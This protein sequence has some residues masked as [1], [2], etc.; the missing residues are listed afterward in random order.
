MK[1]KKLITLV[2]GSGV[3]VA[4]IN[5]NAFVGM[6]VIGLGEFDPEIGRIQSQF[7]ADLKFETEEMTGTS[8][9][10]YKPGKIRDELNMGG[11]QSVMIR[12]LDTNKAYMLMPAMPNMYMEIDPGQNQG[13]NQAPEYKLVSREVVGK[14]EVNG[15]QTTKYKSVY[16]SK[17]GKF[18][19]FTWYTEDNIAVKGFMI[20][21]QKGD[22]QRLKFELSNLQREPQQ[23]SLFE[24]PPGATKFSAMGMMGGGMDMQAMQQQAAQAQQ[25]QQSQSA[26]AST[27]SEA[28]STSQSDEDGGFAGEVTDEAQQSAQDTVVDETG[29]AV[30]KSIRKGFGKLFGR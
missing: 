15:M 1:L 27:A 20:H 21:E 5:A 4:S 22:K 17:D 19:G 18:G 29:N 2:V 23:D 28:T 25:G 10:Y 7:S 12:Q 14:E 3:L 8:K 6:L 9:V 16:E 24:L 30:E 13:K 11:E 26:A